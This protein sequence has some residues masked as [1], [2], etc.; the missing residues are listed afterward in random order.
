MAASHW[1]SCHGEDGSGHCLGRALVALEVQIHGDCATRLG[2]VPPSYC[3]SFAARSPWWALEVA[4]GQPDDSEVAAGR[5]DECPQ[6]RSPR[7]E[8]SAARASHKTQWGTRAFPN[9]NEENGGQRRGLRRDSKPR[10]RVRGDPSRETHLPLQRTTDFG[11]ASRTLAPSLPPPLAAEA[12]HGLRQDEP[13]TRPE[14]T[15]S[16]WQNWGE[17]RTQLRP[18]AGRKAAASSAGGPDPRDAPPPPPAT[19]LEGAPRGSPPPILATSL[20]PPLIAKTRRGLWQDGPRT[21]PE[22]TRSPRG[23]GGGTQTGGYGQCHG[24]ADSRD[25]IYAPGN[26]G[27]PVTNIWT[28]PMGDNSGNPGSFLDR[29]WPGT[30]APS[31]QTDLEDRSRRNN[32]CLLGFPEGIEG[33]DLL[34]YLRDIIPKLTDITFDPPLEFERVHRLGPKRQD[35]KGRPRSII[36]CL[37][38]HG[39]VRQLLQAAR[40]QGPLRLGTLEIR[41]S[42]EFS[43]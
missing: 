17:R 38:R 12:C 11:G 8:G 6:W 14:C 2:G 3:R 16:P 4:E 37:L 21:W 25:K 5:L 31:Q 32:I 30:H 23:D 35:G 10:P 15:R 1:R 24:G 20:P 19:N 9:K 42:A 36:A 39:Q 13:W 26:S 18:A 33:T 22:D 41:L 43:K 27:L 29:Q 34:S 28:G 7:R 40:A